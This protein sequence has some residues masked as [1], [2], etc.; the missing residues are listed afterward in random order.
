[1]RQGHQTVALRRCIE[2]AAEVIGCVRNGVRTKEESIR[3]DA[4]R[5]L[6]GVVTVQAIIGRTMGFPISLRERAAAAPARQ[7]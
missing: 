3:Y 5:P 1:M 6:I 4:C 2:N 7:R